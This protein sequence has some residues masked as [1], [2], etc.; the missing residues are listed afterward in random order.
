MMNKKTLVRTEK[1]RKRETYAKK[2]KKPEKSS[3][4]RNSVG[5]RES[6]HKK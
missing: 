1:L 2:T 4:L 5:K 3:E 6:E